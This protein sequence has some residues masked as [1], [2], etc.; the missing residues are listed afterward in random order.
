M[1]P[2]PATSPRKEGLLAL[3]AFVY[4][5][6]RVIFWMR[7]GVARMATSGL[8]ESDRVGRRFIALKLQTG[9]MTARQLSDVYF[10]MAET[11]ADYTEDERRV[12]Q[13]LKNSFDDLTTVRNDFLHGEWWIGY[14][15]TTGDERAR[16]MPPILSRTKAGRGGD[17]E[18]EKPFAVSDLN[19]R[20]AEIVRLRHAIA[21][22]GELVSDGRPIISQTDPM[23]SEVPRARPGEVYVL[24]GK[25]VVREGPQAAQVPF[26]PRD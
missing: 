2:L 16:E 8:A 10:G 18:T 13:R 1:D 26:I 21:E 25:E 5:F 11:I 14:V 19:T 7:W 15:Q 3:G 17:K 4:E 24:R 23:P 22:W 9:E 12:A 6:S 20:T